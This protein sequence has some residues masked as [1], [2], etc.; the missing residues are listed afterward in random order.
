MAAQLLQDSVPPHVELVHLTGRETMKAITNSERPSARRGAVYDL[1]HHA[2]ARMAG[3]DALL[4]LDPH[5]F[6][7]LVRPGDPS[8]R[9]P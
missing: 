4:T 7:A 8:I 1:L 5:D 2:A 9:P 3:V 6:Q